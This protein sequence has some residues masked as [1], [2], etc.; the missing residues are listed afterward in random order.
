[1]TEKGAGDPPWYRQRHYAHFDRRP[2]REQV[3]RYVTD[4]RRVTRHGFFPF[5]MRPVRICH[6][7]T[8][9]AGRRRHT[10][11][12]RPVTYAAHMDSQIHAYYAFQLN[13]LLEI[14]YQEDFG[15]S[16]LAYRRMQPARSNIDHALDAFSDVLARREA[17]ILAIDVEG[18][19]D[20][21]N[22]AHLKKAWIE[23]LGDSRLPDDHFA[24]YRSVTRDYAI[25]WSHVRR[26]LGER[27]RRRAGKSGEP[28]CS[29]TEFRSRLAH[30]AQPRHRLVWKVKRKNP[31]KCIPV[32]VPVGI[33]QGSA[34]SAV[35][36]N[37]Y[38]LEVDKRLFAALES[39]GATYRRYSD[40]ILVV[41]P[42]GTMS[43]AE[44]EV[45]AALTSVGLAVNDD[46]TERIEFRENGEKIRPTYITRDGGR[47]A[48]RP[49]QYLG[50]AFN[51]EQ[52]R[53]RDGTVSRFLIRL[54][55]AS[56]RG[57]LAA[58]ADKK[59]RIKRRKL[60][61]TMSFLGPGQAYGPWP[62]VAGHR[63]PPNHAPSPGFL[64]YATRAHAKAGTISGV[65]KQRSRAWH[66]LHVAIKAD[67]AKLKRS[68]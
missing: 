63:V 7:K 32:D 2:N 20:G 1:M 17:D 35:L 16:V 33:P 41:C 27:H 22:H 47:H 53:L 56:H 62:R 42:P 15:R 19:F 5:I 23:L 44:S 12:V 40:D 29:P 57:R 43:A 18:F 50:L 49:M 34:I 11:K 30:L 36:A 45:R 59:I 10:H 64:E 6:F 4:P 67:E 39:I 58:R 68:R 37:L 51:G 61:A 8:D 25:E 65:A 21:L 28:I 26:E 54:N 52:A 48:G 66:E 13:Q 9:S 3:V 55:R 14:Q 60:Y 46:K 24:V 38:M 31:P